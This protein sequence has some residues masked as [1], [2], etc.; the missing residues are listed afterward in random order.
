GGVRAG[1][2]GP[3]SR[4]VAGHEVCSASR[5]GPHR[6]IWQGA[7]GLCLRPWWIQCRECLR[8]EEVGGQGGG[9]GPPWTHPVVSEGAGTGPPGQ[10]E[11]TGGGGDRH[12][13]E[14][15]I[16]VQ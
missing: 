14:F 6:D 2:A 7:A 9:T 16:W 13:Q 3:E 8:L 1:H 11:G 5:G 4:R 12:H 10:R 15:E